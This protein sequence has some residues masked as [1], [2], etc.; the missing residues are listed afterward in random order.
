[1]YVRTAVL[2]DEE[3]NLVLFRAI[4]ARCK[5]IEQLDCILDFRMEALFQLLADWTAL[6]R[7]RVEM[8]PH[9]HMSQ[10]AAR[11]V[12]AIPSLCHI[13]LYVLGFDFGSMEDILKASHEYLEKALGSGR[14]FKMCLVIAYCC[15]RQEADKQFDDA[16]KRL[17]SKYPRESFE[18][19]A[20]STRFRS[21][22]VEI[23]SVDRDEMQTE[24]HERLHIRTPDHRLRSLL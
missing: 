12:C 20:F 7:L 17:S 5:N 3:E 15:T 2:H 1:M 16:E 14:A 18:V 11:A 22:F 9:V 23:T 24:L 10:E 19:K 8:A 4:Q 21:H 13:T 6:Q